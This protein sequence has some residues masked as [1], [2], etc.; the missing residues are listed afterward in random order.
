MAFKHPTWQYGQHGILVPYVKPCLQQ[1]KKSEPPASCSFIKKF[2]TMN[3]YFE[4]N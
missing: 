3:F 2:L 4:I 1:S